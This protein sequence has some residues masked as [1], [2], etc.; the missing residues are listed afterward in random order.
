MEKTEYPG[1]TFVILKEGMMVFKLITIK[2]IKLYYPAAP[3]SLFLPWAIK[4]NV[5]TQTLGQRVAVSNMP[6]DG[7]PLAGKLRKG[8]GPRSSLVRAL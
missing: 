8:Q 6:W 7:P 1:H 4:E 3:W 5:A 2:W